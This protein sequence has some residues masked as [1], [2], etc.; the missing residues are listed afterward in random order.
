MTRWYLSSPPRPNGTGITVAVTVN[1]RNIITEAAPIARK[2]IG[3]PIRNLER[4]AKVDVVEVIAH[5]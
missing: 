5:Y 3:Q 2:F 4:W 1:D